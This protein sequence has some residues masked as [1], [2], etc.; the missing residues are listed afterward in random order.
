MLVLGFFKLIF[1]F[2][3]LTLEVILFLNMFLVFSF[4]YSV[5]L[6]RHDIQLL[7]ELGILQ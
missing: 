3:K 7:L 2:Q 6:L 4:D 1:E 5:E